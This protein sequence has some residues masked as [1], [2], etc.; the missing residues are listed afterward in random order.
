MSQL[1]FGQ[2]RDLWLSVGGP[3]GAA[4][5]AAAIAIAESGGRTDAHN[6]VPP[7]DSYGLWQINY[8]GN[9]RAPRTARYGAPAA[10]LADPMLQARAA[11]DISGGGTNFKPWSTFTSGAYLRYMPNKTNPIPVG[12]T[13][14]PAPIVTL[15][16]TPTGKGYWLVTADGAVYSFGDAEYH[17]GLRPE[18]DHY[19]TAEAH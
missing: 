18:G 2:I 9:L 15:A 7:D 12:G 6:P 19:V 10:L 8:L 11:L 16:P 13:H 1:T 14:L 17:G 5:T 3:T 4:D